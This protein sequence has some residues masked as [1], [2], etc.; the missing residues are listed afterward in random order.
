[1][2]SEKAILAEQSML[3]MCALVVS[4][5]GGQ[6][7]ESPYASVFRPNFQFPSF[8]GRVTLHDVAPEDAGEALRLVREAGQMFVSWTQGSVPENMGELLRDAG[9]VPMTT[10]TGTGL[11]PSDTAVAMAIGPI[12]LA[13]AVLEV[14]SDSS[15]EVTANRV[16]NRYSDG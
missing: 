9:C 8:Y 13:T 6:H 2:R 5:T 12:R 7:L 11:K 10:Q 3:D 14:S 16:R 1:M 15:R 4:L